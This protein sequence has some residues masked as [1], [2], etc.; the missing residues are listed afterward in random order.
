VFTLLTGGITGGKG[1]STRRHLMRSRVAE[2]WEVRIGPSGR[3]VLWAGL[4]SAVVAA[5][6]IGPVVAPARA[7][8][9]APE[10]LSTP[11][12][13]EPEAAIDANGNAIAVWSHYDGA[14]WRVQ[15]RRVASTGALGPVKTISAAGDNSLS[16]QIAG[17]P[18]G[19]AIVVWSLRR[20]EDR[21]VEAQTMSDSGRLGAVKTIS[22]PGRNARRPRI[23]SDA[24]GDAT[25]VWPQ[26]RG[27]TWRIKAR[28]VSSTGAL[29]PVKTLSSAT[30]DS[31]APEI[32]SDAHG[33]AIAVW[34]QIDGRKVRIKAR[35]ISAKG[36]LGSV[37]T[38][39]AAGGKAYLPQ[40][41]SDARGDALVVW[42]ANREGSGWH[43]NARRISRTGAVGHVMTLADRAG[44]AQVASG[45]RGDSV[46]VWAD[47]VGRD[48]IQARQI[49]ATSELGPIQ[50]LSTAGRSARAPQI[51]ID[52][53]GD[54]TAVWYDYHSVNDPSD[55]HLQTRQISA[56]GA[57]SPQQTLAIAVI[58]DPQI[59]VNGAGDAFAVWS[60]FT[61]SEYSAWGSLGP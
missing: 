15:A 1:M 46:A 59:A 28:K 40:V 14:K 41:A 51:G 30:Q 48:R 21:R 2:P 58:R 3:K 34:S 39:S 26:K 50:T 5:L 8:F 22:S 36:R 17:D 52:D 29:G 25:V 38:L 4:G 35:K 23:A 45:A 60:Q 27:G 18:G 6:M 47:L 31:E 32:A 54:A 44:E 13:E 56:T 53:S 33:G 12:A 11:V 57:L 49:S 55:W 61:G 24:N 43:V 37:K 10:K 9:S 16:P 20:G 7:A 19:G 42:Q